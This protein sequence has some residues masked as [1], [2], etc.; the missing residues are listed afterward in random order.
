M[1][2]AASPITGTLSNG[3]GLTS[4]YTVNLTDG[5]LTVTPATVNYTIAN[6]SHVYGT[7]DSFS[8]LAATIATGVNSEYLDIAYSSV[9]NTVTAHVGSSSPIT[10]TLSNGTG[11]TSDYTVN[12]TDS[13]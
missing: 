12:L 7:T 8:T 10:G 1:S 13:P 5:A 11:L 4:D 3:T 2:A 9:G 6:D